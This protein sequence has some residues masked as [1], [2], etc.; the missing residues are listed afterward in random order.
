TQVNPEKEKFWTH[1]LADGCRLA[2]L[3]KFGGI[4]LD[5]DI[6]SLRSMPFANFTCQEQAGIF[7]NAALGFPHKHHPFIWNCMEGFV[8]NIIEHVWVQQGPQMITR[9][10]KKWCQ[11]DNLT[12]FM[13]TECNG[14]SLWITSRFYPIP[15]SGWEKYCIAW[16]K[17]DRE[18]TFLATYGIHVWNFMNSS[19]KRN[20]V[21]GNGSLLE[22]DFQMY[23]PTSYRILI[24]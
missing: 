12:A 8:V 4:Y 10:L 21:A 15:Y 1:V 19:K 16:K 5:T 6:I 14:I 9:V 20:L 18:Q 11:I 7:N 23:C 2:L 22:Y 13:G 17:E 3:W 24:H